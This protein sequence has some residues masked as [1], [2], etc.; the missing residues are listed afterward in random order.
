MNNLEL[1]RSMENN[2]IDLIY[3]DILYGTGRN[4]GQY[5]DLNQ[6]KREIYKH[7]VPRIKEMKRVLKNTGQIYLQMDYRINHWIR[8]ILDNVFGI[9]NFRNE[10]IWHYRSAPRKKNCFGNR[11][12]TIIRYSKTDKFIFNEDEVRV[13]YRPSAARVSGY[14]MDAYNS[15]GK[16]VG[17]VWNDLPMLAQGDKKERNG[18]PTQKPIH[19]LDRIIKAST[20]KGD[21]VAD[22][23]CGSG[24]TMVSAKRLNRQ[25]I[26]CDI[27]SEAVTLTNKRLA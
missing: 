2:S 4:F 5:K 14:K 11:H 9:D 10:I 8:D 19:L 22:F 20:N 26:G 1:L 24:T 23:Y 21:I 17:D 13:P 27:S 18:Y 16:V 3:S 6:D 7:Y 12:D 15:K 25:Y